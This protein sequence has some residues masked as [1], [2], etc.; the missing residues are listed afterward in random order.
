MGTR[1]GLSDEMRPFPNQRLAGLVCRMRLA[2]DDELHRA[3]A[4]AQKAKQPL[5]VMQQQV[6]SFVGREPA[7]KAQREGVGIK[8]LLRGFYLR[9]QRAG[10]RQVH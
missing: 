9:G 1:P 5:G 10:G 8:E 4:V 6:R 3:L 2:G 7:R